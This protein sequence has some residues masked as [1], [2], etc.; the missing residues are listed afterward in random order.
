MSTRFDPDEDDR[1]RGSFATGRRMPA[2]TGPDIGDLGPR[3]EEPAEKRL[4]GLPRVPEEL[5]EDMPGRGMHRDDEP[6]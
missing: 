3:I 2:T 4:A 6:G 1:D 5:P